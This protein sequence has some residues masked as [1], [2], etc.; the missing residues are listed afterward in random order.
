MTLHMPG[1]AGQSEAL[2]YVVG[3]KRELN[4]SQGEIYMVNAGRVDL[5]VTG[6]FRRA[7]LELGATGALDFLPTARPIGE[8]AAHLLARRGTSAQAQIG[9]RFRADPA[10]D[11]RVSVA[12]RTVAGPVHRAQLRAGRAETSPDG[13]AR[14]LT[15][16]RL[17][18]CPRSRAAVRGTAPAVAAGRR[19]QWRSCGC[20]PVPAPPPLRSP[21]PPP[22]STRLFATTRTTGGY[23][24]RRAWQRPLPPPVGI[25]LQVG[26][27]GEEQLDGSHTACQRS[28]GVGA[29]RI[30]RR[31]AASSMRHCSSNPT[32]SV[33]PY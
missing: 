24:R 20:P 31:A 12:V 7:S 23:H 6:D 10:P 14:L 22:S 15:D 32:I 4:W 13:L 5:G 29:R 16:R 2:L 19:W 11:R 21:D 9:R 30:R 18:N 26:R 1:R 33:I 3:G 27:V 8:K 28:R 25:G 17:A